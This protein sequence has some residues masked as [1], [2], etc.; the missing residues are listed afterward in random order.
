MLCSRY[1]INDEN[2][3]NFSRPLLSNCKTGY[4]CTAYMCHGDEI[5]WSDAHISRYFE[6]EI[7]VQFSSKKKLVFKVRLL[8]L[9]NAM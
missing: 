1:Y 4:W 8:S 7:R 5:N 6:S 3:H 2:L 9:S